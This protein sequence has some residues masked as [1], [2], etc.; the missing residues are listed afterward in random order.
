MKNLISLFILICC[1]INAES[2]TILAPIDYQNPDDSYFDLQDRFGNKYIPYFREDSVRKI[3]D[4]FLGNDINVLCVIP[5]S[6]NKDLLARI[7]LFIDGKIDWSSLV[8]DF[9]DSNESK[10]LVLYSEYECDQE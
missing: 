3:Q 2:Q 10:W 5:R 6:T 9:F 4:E 7:D 8:K 1:G